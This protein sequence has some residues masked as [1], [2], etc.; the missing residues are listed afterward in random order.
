M[1]CG[2]EVLSYVMAREFTILVTSTGWGK[3]VAFF[4]PVIFI[5]LL[6]N[7]WGVLR[8]YGLKIIHVNSNG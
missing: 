2:I 8:S 3:T 5:H 7:Y 6:L 4:G 1:D